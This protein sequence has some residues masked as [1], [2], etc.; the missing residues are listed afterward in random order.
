MTQYTPAQLT[1]VTQLT[2][3]AA[4]LYSVPSAT[5]TTVK[6]VTIANVTAT[7]AQVT[8]YLVPNGGSAATTNAVLGSVNVS[9][10]TTT[11]IDTA[12]IIPASSTIQAKA[13]AGSA[14]NVHISGIER[15]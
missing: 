8:I 3:S 13:S 5:V 6:T 11:I 4:T 1:A 9:A 2:T 7:D 15:A 12:W 14:I 10:N